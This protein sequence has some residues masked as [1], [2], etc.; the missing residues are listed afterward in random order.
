MWD[1][2]LKDYPQA[3]RQ[4]IHEC[5]DVIESNVRK[6]IG[7]LRVRTGN[8]S[9]AVTR[10]EGSGGGYVV[11]KND[12]NIARHC[13][14]LEEG[15]KQTAGQFVSGYWTDPK[16]FW[17][18]RGMKTGM[19]HK[20]TYVKGYHMYYKAAEDSREQIYGGAER[21]IESVVERAIG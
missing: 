14:L 20:K 21:M 8:L 19:K 16:M 15:H 2:F 5:G 13:H 7:E 12:N 17:N 9:K 11:V 6:R 3:R 18:V 1:S 4:Y 10:R